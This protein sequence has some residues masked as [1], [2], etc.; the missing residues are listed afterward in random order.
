MDI[1]RWLS[2]LGLGKY[3]PV[4]AEN[5]IDSDALPHLTEEHLKELGLPL[6][7]RVKVIA[8]IKRL[9]EASRAAPGTRGINHPSPAQEPGS[10]TAERRQLT[11]MFCDLVGSTA[12]ASR[13][14]PEDLREV[15][16]TYHRCCTEQITK[17]GGFV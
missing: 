13:L 1:A 11:V 14:D 10:A 7:A 15:I 5:E 6:G 12:L 17:A 9:G 16:G 4:F 2:G 3:A 8:E